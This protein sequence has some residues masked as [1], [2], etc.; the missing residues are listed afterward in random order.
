MAF[1]R[2]YTNEEGVD[3]FVA[4]SIR[5]GATFKNTKRKIC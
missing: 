2:R 4:V 1:K 5:K 3:S